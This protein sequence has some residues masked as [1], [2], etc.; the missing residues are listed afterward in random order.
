MRHVCRVPCAVCRVPCARTPPPN[1]SVSVGVILL[2]MEAQ[3]SG[4]TS[5]EF[6][7]DFLLSLR[8]RGEPMMAWEGHDIMEQVKKNIIKRKKK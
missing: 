5:G 1:V 6:Y 4:L 2:N 7:A 3:R 8:Q